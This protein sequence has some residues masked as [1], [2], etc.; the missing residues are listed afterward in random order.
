MSNKN[1]YF[2]LQIKPSSNYELFLDFLIDAFPDGFEERSGEIIL[3]SEEP[4]D[5]IIWGL[6]LF[7][8]ELSKALSTEINLKLNLSVKQNE[9]WIEKYKN[10]IEPIFVE[11]FYVYPSWHSPKENATNIQINPALAFGSGH[12]ETTSSCL[13]FIANFGDEVQNNRNLD[14]LDVGTGSGILAIAGRNLGF[15]VDFCDTDEL[16]V[17]S[18]K[19]NFK[20]NNLDYSNAWVGSVS[21]SPENKKYDLIVAN[22]VADVLVILSHQLVNKLKPSGK[23]I[24]SGILN[25][26]KSDEQKVKNAFESIKSENS[27]LKLEKEFRKNEWTTL[28]YSF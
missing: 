18:A 14:F 9:D 2:E 16:A 4:L 26:N 21:K 24:L 7:K 5:E 25:S 6:E 13:K 8:T 20:I 19:E 22:I 12:H 11:P 10:S 1:E 15:N 27:K 23:L 28:L 3:R 17:Q